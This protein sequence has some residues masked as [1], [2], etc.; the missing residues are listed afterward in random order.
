MKQKYL[1]L[2]NSIVDFLYNNQVEIPEINLKDKHKI[3]FTKE[4]KSYEFYFKISNKKLYY[5]IDKKNFKGPFNEGELFRL[6]PFKSEK[7]ERTIT[8]NKFKLLKR[9]YYQTLTLT[10]HF[11]LGGLSFENKKL[12]SE[13]ITKLK[14]RKNDSL[15][16]GIL[17][18]FTFK[19][20]KPVL[21]CFENG[22]IFDNNINNEGNK[23]TPRV[24]GA[25]YADAY[26]SYCFARKYLNTKKEKY[27]HACF[28]SLDYINRTYE[29]YPK[30]IVWY[31]HD[32]KNP[33][34]IETI[35]LLKKNKIDVRN[36]ENLIYKFRPNFYEPTNVFALRFYWR[37]LR[38]IFYKKENKL[39]LKRCYY[40]LKKDQTKDGLILDRNLEDYKE[41]FDLT[42]HQYSLA[43]LA[44]GLK[45]KNDKNFKKIFL[46]GCKFS[47]SMLLPDG[48]VSYNGRAANNIYHLASA[49]YT[50]E[51]ARNRYNFK[52]EGLEEMFN[53]LVQWLNKDGSLPVC[54]NYYGKQRMAWNHCRTP[55][56]AL[57]AFLLYNAID[58]SLEKTNPIKN[59]F[60]CNTKSRYTA[61]VNDNYFFAFFAGAKESYPLSGNSHKTGVAGIANFGTKNNKSKYL[62]LDRL[63]SS[64]DLVTDLPTIYVNNKK[65][66]PVSKGQIKKL[67][68]M[69]LMYPLLQ[70]MFKV[71]VC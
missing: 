20:D 55:Y 66:E 46:K 41:A 53:Y 37:N 28:R 60:I 23:L 8:F 3:K 6:N 43:C 39:K 17:F 11:I 13:F 54:M 51:F 7:T 31:H 56:N 15:E 24:M 35:L 4:G 62:I 9:L 63:L 27:L 33:A 64:K 50:F 22:G 52:S 48:E 61:F 34:Y 65:Y 16:G 1:K 58:E 45:Y 18:Y 68:K 49:I 57:V 2:C 42:Y 70:D 47:R 30:S 12:F 69:V 29:N 5:S 44:G 25:Y 10:K 59:K 19:G 32:F 36:Y 71:E 26:A 14:R 38:K 67:K 40:R 21:N